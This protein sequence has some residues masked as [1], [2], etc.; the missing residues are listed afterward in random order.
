LANRIELSEEVRR[1]L[2]DSANL[3]SEI[4]INGTNYVPDA[5]VDAGHKGAIWRVHDHLGRPRALK[6]SIFEDY[7]DRSFL[8]ET[9]RAAKLEP[10]REF[11][12]F[13]DAGV[14]DLP[15]GDLGQHRF[16]AMIQEWVDGQTLKAFLRDQ[17]EQVTGSF[18]VAY[19]QAMCNAL[20]VLNTLDLT[21]DDLHFNNVMLAYPAPGDL[22]QELSVKVI[23]SGSLKPAPT[24]K[25]KD[26][27]RRFVEHLIEIWNVIHGRPLKVARERRFLTAAEGLI[28]S[29]VS[30]APGIAL[31]EPRQIRKQFEI[32]WTRANGPD[33]GGADGSAPRMSS[34]FEFLSAEHIADDALLV[35]I[36]AESCPW[37]SKVAG[38]DPCLVTGPRGCGKSTIFRWL[39]LKAH[40]HRE[41][42][43]IAPYGLVGFYISC[44]SDLQNR[45]GWIKSEELAWKFHREIVHYFNLL[46]AREVVHTLDLIAGREDRESYWGFGRAQ[47]IAVHN[48]VM[49]WLSPNVGPRVQG[50]SYMQQAMEAIEDEMFSVHLAI[51]MG[52]TLSH[53]TPETFLGN[54]SSLLVEVVSG[55]RDKHIVFL[56]DD[57]STHR[58]PEAVQVA[59]NR[60]IW[61]RRPTHVFK[62]SSEK[63][64]AILRDAFGSPIDA[65][66][67]MI[68]IDCGREFI[69][70]DDVNQRARSKR[71]AIDLLDNRLRAAGFVGTAA[72]L[73][74]HSEW[75]EGSLARALVSRSGGRGRAEYHGLECISDLCSGDIATLLY[76]YSEIFEAGGVTRASRQRVS[77]HIQ[78]RSIRKI[79]Q[80][81]L[82]A[83][84]PS[85]PFGSD[86]YATANEFGKLVRKILDQGRWHKKGSGSVP[87]QCPRIEIDQDASG[88][89][90]VLTDQEKSLALEL[91]RRAV[92]ID[93]GLGSSRHENATTMR[94]HFRRIYLPAFTAALAKNDA[95]KENAWWFK[96]FL[97][98][99]GEACDHIWKGW[100]KH[101]DGPVVEQLSLKRSNQ[102]G[103][104]C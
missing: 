84:R 81:Q 91:I 88:A 24:R 33:Y 65:T 93:M 12:K 5:A 4:A 41:E 66:R 13:I 17:R 23:D 99:P 48:F 26:D 71:F 94:W 96:F 39:S 15:L 97:E 54:L 72:E 80:S 14:I 30:D 45:L 6:L 67:E 25:E 19:V 27:H 78:H 35:Q 101:V 90:E 61:E 51:L 74:G 16:V 60:V 36:F 57:F 75:P 85:F 56:V 10:Y 46:A 37:L 2:L 7:V 53:T 44:S 87:A 34:P 40:L 3:P 70:L 104:D 43:D 59:L 1:Y 38:P 77:P 73:L 103:S 58:L 11:A 69:A 63:Y 79:S 49:K 18:F 29:M 8:Q 22:S 64:G 28:Q 102:S 47:E 89:F 52:D 32:A 50:V 68:E 82:E 86:M 100:Q 9:T 31:T 95:V 42:V 76:L 98:R 62:L 92:F 83:I 20:N 21:H 55:F